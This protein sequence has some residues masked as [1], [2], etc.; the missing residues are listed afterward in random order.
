MEHSR[1]SSNICYRHEQAAQLE[2]TAFPYRPL[3][4]QESDI[5]LC[6]GSISQTFVELSSLIAFD[7]WWCLVGTKKGQFPA[8]L[9]LSK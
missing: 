8:F 2:A 5:K 3:I 6:W 9:L 7:K 4:L 1:H